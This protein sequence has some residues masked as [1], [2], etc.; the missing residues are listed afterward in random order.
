MPGTASTAKF[1]SYSAIASREAEKSASL[2]AASRF[3]LPL[4]MAVASMSQP[5]P[6]LGSTI[7]IGAPS[8]FD[9]MARYSNAM[10]IGN[11]PCAAILHGLEP[12]C[13]YRPMFLC[14]ASMYCQ[15]FCSPII[16]SQALTSRKP[17]PDEAG[18]GITTLPA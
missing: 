3:L 16:C 18:C 14:R 15:P 4:T 10:P 7:S 11:S 6:S 17:V 5:R 2:R 9:F 13:V 1:F 8:F 12:E